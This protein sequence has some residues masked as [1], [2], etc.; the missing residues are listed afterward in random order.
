M[1]DI[2]IIFFD[3][4]GTLIDM[5][6]EQM[7]DQIIYTLTQLKNKGIKICVATGRSQYL[8]KDLPIKFDAYLTYNGSYCFNDEEVIFS[9]PLHKQDIDAIIQNANLLQKPLSLATKDKYAANGSDS[10][11]QQYFNFGG[12]DVQITNDFNKIV[13]QDEIFQ[14]MISATKQE[15][16]VILQNTTA[17]VITA[18]WDYAV[19]IIPKNS[20]KGN[21][22]KKILDYYQIPQEQ[23]MAF[24]DGNNDIAMLQKVG[25]GV[26]MQNASKELKSIADDICDSVSNDGI[27][28]Y[29]KQHGLID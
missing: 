18:W 12:I 10:Y 25:I 8:L 13:E 14:I 15:Y 21:A 3:V 2:K 4:D 28:T 17:S 24:G 27:Y 11:L 1:K 19:D 20:G 29:C 5:K 22:V 26:A 6:Q 23:S 16:D 9:N 7:S